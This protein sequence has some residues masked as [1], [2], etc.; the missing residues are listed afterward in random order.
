MTLCLSG[1]STSGTVG[2]NFN[3]TAHADQGGPSYDAPVARNERDQ[4]A[5]GHAAHVVEE[6]HHQCDVIAYGKIGTLEN[7]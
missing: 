5:C 7:R 3:H 2:G 4:L 6:V 1:R